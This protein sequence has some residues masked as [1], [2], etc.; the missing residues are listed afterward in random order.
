MGSVELKLTPVDPQQYVARRRV[1]DPRLGELVRPVTS[2]KRMT[3]GDVVIVG[4]PE[5]RGVAVNAGRTGA[6]AGPQHF[7]QRFYSLT[8]GGAAEFPSARCW[9]AG[10][11]VCGATHEVTHENLTAVVAQ[12]VSAQALP[13]VIGGSHDNTFG[14]IRGVCRATI[15]PAVINLDAHLD[16]RACEPDG[17][18]GSGTSFRR[19]IDEKI[20][21]GNQLT[22][23]G[24]QSQHASHAHV[25][26]A[27]EQ[28]VHLWSFSETRLPDPAQLF[29]NIIQ[30][31]LRNH[32]ALA[33]SLDLDCI[34]AGSAP[35]VSAPSVQG[36]TATQI[37]G[38]LQ[39][40]Q[41][42]G[43]LAYLDIMELCPAHDID[44]RTAR[45]AALLVWQVI[46]CSSSSPIGER[47]G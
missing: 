34:D 15:T 8:P 18:I 46:V 7:R 22:N 30:A 37:V 12:I 4:V 24:Y 47:A 26:W 5:D 40:A 17:R 21:A 45:L 3:G 6:A 16:V 11:V 9:D 27:R 41:Q 25:T 20:I 10:D 43:A 36:F 29:G 2:W 33:L 31:S 13:I 1:E 32:R 14:G 19:L 23:F 28:G 39:L 38:M 35:G 44:D 42:S